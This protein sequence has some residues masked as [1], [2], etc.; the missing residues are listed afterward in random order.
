VRE[1]VGRKGKRRWA[2]SVAWGRWRLTTGLWR[3]LA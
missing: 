2:K 1:D 3:M